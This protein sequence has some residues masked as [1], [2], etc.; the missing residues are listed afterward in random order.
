[1]KI[2]HRYILAELAGPFLLGLSAFTLVVLLHRL[3]RLF[4]LLVAKGVPAALAGRLLLTLFPVFLQITLP[5]ALLLAVLL[6]FGRL[7]ADA[8]TTAFAAGGAGLADLAVP[9][10]AFSALVFA[11]SLWVAW[12]GVSWGTREMRATLARIAAARAGAGASERV[13]QEVGKEVLLYPDKVDRAGEKMEG[14]FLA[15]RSARGEPLLVFAREGRFGDAVAGKEGEGDA[16]SM[17]LSGGEA[18]HGGSRGGWTVLDFRE[19]SFRL[20]LGTG[21]APR[22]DDPRDMDLASMR[23]RGAELRGTP[24][25]ASFAYHFHRRLSLAVSCLSF[26]LVGVPIALSRR[27]RGKSPA[28]GLTVAVTVAFYLFVALAG[29]M[30]RKS[31]PATVALLWAPNVVALAAFALALRRSEGGSFRGRPAGRESAA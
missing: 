19:L 13:F 18:H 29:A 16:L 27:G 4:E 11:A 5:A 6:A 3:S 22:K 23:A 26:G 17:T 1:M 24:K 28:F 14:I 20:P 9:V 21:G 31:V 7:S 12:T 8:E 2:L 15:R 25:G 30:E 10:A